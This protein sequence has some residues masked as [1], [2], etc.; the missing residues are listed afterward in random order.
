MAPETRTCQNCKNSFEIEPEDFGFY[1]KIKVPPPT[2]CS[3]CRLQRR[4]AFRNERVLFRRKDDA[5][6]KDILSG[7]PPDMPFPVYERDYWWSDAWDPM[8]YGREFDETR[9]FLNQFRELMNT[10]PHSSRS[11][12]NL[13]NS[14][15]TDQAGY[16]KNC[17]LC[18]NCDY[19]EDSTYVIRGNTS[20]DCCDALQVQGAELCYD[21]ALIDKSSWVFYSEDCESSTDIWF[22]KQCVGCTDCFGCV[23]LRQKK[24][25]IWNQPYTKEEY[26][27]KLEEMRLDS[28]E[29]IA[30]LKEEAHRFWL[31]FPSKYYRGIRNVNSSGEM[32]NDTK[33][34]RDCWWVTDSQ[35]SRYCQALYL[36]S[37]DCYDY[38]VWGNQATRVYEALTCGEEVDSLKFCFD[39]FMS[40]RN[41]EHCMSCISS[42]DLFGCVG[43]KKKQYCILNKQYAKE[44]YESLREKI[45]AQMNTMPYL[46][47]R[48][49]GGEPIPYRYGEFFPPE[50]SPFA[51]NETM[52]QDTFPLTKEEAAAKGY[53]WREPEKREFQTT[54]EGSDLPDRLSDV[55][56]EVLKEI[57]GCTAC[58]RAYRIVPAEL[59]FHR[60]IGAPL[61]NRCPDCRHA[62]RFKFINPP[63]FFRRG[64]A[65]AGGGD[66]TGTYANTTTHFHGAERCPNSFETA[67]APDRPD[68]VYCE[69][70]YQ[71]E[72]V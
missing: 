67:Y 10:V 8:Q 21:S 7:F 15:Y 66:G 48:R 30:R 36:R 9:P 64:C 56:D 20:K 4:L 57:I 51:Y 43:L 69:Q 58:G 42:S 16:L 26:K 19:V 5:S 28:R 70:C 65:C 32:L 33:N 38:T 34:A 3:S 60:R 61:P 35:D 47:P 17:Y 53:A 39:C 40:C 31:K 29:S 41:L 23:G 1:E 13:V 55:K 12:V 63:K 18:F 6:G 25:H 72:V 62:E 44:E 22:S 27:K 24:Y 59:Q 50:F 71:A 52:L 14:E 49:G 11:V 37:A 46:S 54:I 68:I 2:F 45:I